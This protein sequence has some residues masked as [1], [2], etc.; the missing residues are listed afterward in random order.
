LGAVFGMFRWG[1]SARK[2]KSNAYIPPANVPPE[3]D[4]IEEAG[5]DNEQ[6][7]EEHK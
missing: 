6:M 3:L 2:I 7:D 4:L 1:K 5:D